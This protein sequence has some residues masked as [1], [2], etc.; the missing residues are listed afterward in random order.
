[1]YNI[2]VSIDNGLGIRGIIAVKTDVSC[3]HRGSQYAYSID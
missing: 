1:M 2:F 3:E